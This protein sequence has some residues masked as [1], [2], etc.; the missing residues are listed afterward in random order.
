LAGRR[1]NDA[2]FADLLQAG[3]CPV[4]QRQS[5]AFDRGHA[6]RLQSLD[7]RAETHHQWQRSDACRIGSVGMLVLPLYGLHRGPSIASDIQQPSA[8]QTHEPFVATGSVGMA[9]ERLDVDRESPTACAPSTTHKMP[10]LRANAAIS[11]IGMRRQVEV[12]TWL[13]LITRVAGVIAAAKRR[14]IAAGS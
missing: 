4:A 11:A 9:T 5:T 1:A 7:R 8:F 13:T 2:Q 14:T 6:N 12:M 10:W 3:V